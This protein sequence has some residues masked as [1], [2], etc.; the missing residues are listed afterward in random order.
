LMAAVPVIILF[1]FLQK[2][3]IGGL[4]AGSVKG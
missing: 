3:I 2:W 1:L 4:T